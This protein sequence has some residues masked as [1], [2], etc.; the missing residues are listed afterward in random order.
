VH[1]AP[2]D[3]PAD[4]DPPALV[5]PPELVD[6][7]APG[8]PPIPPPQG[9]ILVSHFPFTHAPVA[10]DELP[11][12]QSVQIA[13]TRHSAALVHS[14]PPPVAPEPAVP[15]PGAPPPLTPP[16]DVEPPAPVEPPPPP[17]QSGYEIWHSPLTH[18]PVAHELPPF[19]QTRQRSGTA[20]S[21]SA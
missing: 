5:T 1:S 16:L 18:D 8:E 12:E 20:H 14:E 2:V 7:P 10:H 11:S 15:P 13:G 9:G 21:L 4:V 3:P 19:A 17:A 6:P